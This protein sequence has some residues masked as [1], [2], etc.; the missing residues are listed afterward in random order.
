MLNERTIKIERTKLKLNNT[1]SQA[2]GDVKMNET[3]PYRG[4]IPFGI[5]LI[6]LRSVSTFLDADLVKISYGLLPTRFPS[7]YYG[8]QLWLA[9]HVVS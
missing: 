6:R 1:N 9:K 8:I 2:D 3:S 7:L 4:A 5:C